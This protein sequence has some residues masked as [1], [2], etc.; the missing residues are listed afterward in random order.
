MK[1]V[2]YVALCLAIAAS[3]A[4]T[5]R[6]QGRYLDA[7]VSG[8]YAGAAYLSQDEADGYAGGLGFSAQGAV[9]FGVQYSSYDMWN[10]RTYTSVIEQIR[11]H[12]IKPTPEQPVGVSLMLAFEQGRHKY[13]EEEYRRSYTAS[14]SS[15]LMG[16]EVV[17]ASFGKG[18]IDVFPYLG[19]TVQMSKYEGIDMGWAKPVHAGAAV[20]VDDR[21]VLEGTATNYESGNAYALSVGALF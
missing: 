19:I 9:D 13:S 12:Y 7:G 20:V 10:G 5:V 3:W 11:G 15:M 16:G 2:L 6:A 21:L 18:R 1:H 17:L 4:S 8:W 14:T